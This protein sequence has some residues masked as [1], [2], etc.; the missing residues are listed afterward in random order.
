MTI[1]HYRLS[2]PFIAKIAAIALL[3]GLVAGEFRPAIAKDEKAPAE[4][5]INTKTSRVY[6]YVGKVG[7]GHEH[8]IAGQVK[9]GIIHFGAKSDAGEIVFDMPTFV[10]DSAASRKYLGLQGT[11]AASTAKEVTAN[12]L[13]ADVLDVRKYPTATFKI[14]SAL[15]LKKRTDNAHPLYRLEGEFTLHGVTRPLQLDAEILE[16][17][18][19]IRVRGSFGIRQTTFGIRPY[20][21]AFG[22]VG[23]T[24]ELSIHGD[25][26]LAKAPVAAGRDRDQK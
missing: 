11:T 2:P 19:G 18:D 17:D 25:I 16:Q 5:D 15:P 24:D 1:Y 21:K 23:V 22:A 6:I 20:S 13:G 12:M 3:T 10:A 7:L 26:I 4:G 14:A 9:A 8:A